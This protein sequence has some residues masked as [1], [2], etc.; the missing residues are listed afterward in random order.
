MTTNFFALKL[1]KRKTRFNFK[2]FIRNF[3][4]EHYIYNEEFFRSI[5]ND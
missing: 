3:F 5:R 1:Y 4:G 2:K